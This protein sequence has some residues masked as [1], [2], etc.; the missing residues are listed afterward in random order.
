M[1]SYFC[2]IIEYAGFRLPNRR[3]FEKG[4]I[5]VR[6]PDRIEAFYKRL[7]KAWK[8]Y[9]DWLFGQLMVNVLGRWHLAEEIRFFRRRM[10]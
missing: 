10:R 7:A 3:R 5:N 9:P 8:N 2:L 6:N 1:I 4:K